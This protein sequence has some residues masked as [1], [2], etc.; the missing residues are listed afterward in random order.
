MVFT[1]CVG[2]NYTSCDIA[3]TAGGHVYV[4]HWSS[5]TIENTA[6]LLFDIVSICAVYWCEC[7]WSFSPCAKIKNKLCAHVTG[8]IRVSSR[9][10]P[11][12]DSILWPV[13]FIFW[14]VARIHTLT[15]WQGVVWRSWMRKMC[16]YS[17]DTI[18][19]PVFLE[20][21]QTLTILTL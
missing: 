4:S 21:R 5:S 3:F 6:E 19:N 7:A 9:I 15:H 10:R 18:K 11:G 8:V 1:Q 12:F 20:T 13:S 14:G 17:D 2:S 16:V